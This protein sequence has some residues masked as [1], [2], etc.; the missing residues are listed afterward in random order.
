MLGLPCSYQHRDGGQSTGLVG[1]R[2]L[3]ALTSL[4]AYEAASSSGRVSSRTLAKGKRRPLPGLKGPLP[5]LLLPRTR[6][7]QVGSH[8]PLLM[9]IGSMALQDVGRLHS[10]IPK[11]ECFGAGVKV[12]NAFK[13]RI[14]ELV[15]DVSVDNLLRAA[16]ALRVYAEVDDLALIEEVERTMPGGQQS[17][18]SKLAP[19]QCPYR[20]LEERIGKINFS[21]RDDLSV[22]EICLHAATC[23][24]DQGLIRPD[25]REAVLGSLMRW[26][27][28]SALV[29][30]RRQLPVLLRLTQEH[31]PVLAALE[32]RLIRRA[33]RGFP[34]A[35]SL[36]SFLQFV[37]DIQ[38][39]GLRLL[40]GPGAAVLDPPSVHY[41]PPLRLASLNAL[42]EV[43]LHWPL[44]RLAEEFS[45][46]VLCFCREFESDV[47]PQIRLALTQRAVL[48]LETFSDVVQRE[49][50]CVDLQQEFI[51]WA[52]F[53]CSAAT[54][55]L[56][57]PGP[58][59]M[60]QMLAG[61]L[62]FGSIAFSAAALTPGCPEMPSGFLGRAKEL[63]PR[64][65]ELMEGLAQVKSYLLGTPVL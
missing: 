20:A 23:L 40:D 22:L 24:R 27:E 39:G 34:S 33:C 48:A 12:R 18:P 6:D 55:D 63:A 64:S 54:E 62:T 49:G 46:S 59:P 8:V 53:C 38:A 19:M 36:G 37:L 31:P 26:T 3:P 5:A 16:E 65:G 21:H 10:E 13:T 14:A 15:A 11:V 4:H 9:D 32:Q 56:L 28:E 30:L 60:A 1:S 57:R 50:N 17:P 35:G 2:S 47:K 52:A 58:R 45:G 25:I 51:Y 7:R 41:I 44:R 61:P 43:L 42:R 29:E